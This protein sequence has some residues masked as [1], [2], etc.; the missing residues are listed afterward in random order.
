[1][2]KLRDVAAILLVIYK[3]WLLLLM[4]YDH[5]NLFFV[6]PWSNV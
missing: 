2:D 3:N 6:V 4:K 5:L 1:M